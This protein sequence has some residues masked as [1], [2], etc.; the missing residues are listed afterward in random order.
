MNQPG[1]IVVYERSGDGW[2]TIDDFPFQSAYDSVGLRS[3]LRVMAD[4]LDTCLILVSKKVEGIAYQELNRLGFSI[5][6]AEQINDSVL[7]GVI[8][9]ILE[10]EKKEN[11]ATPK[12]P[13]SPMQDDHFLLDLVKLQE[14]YPDIS[15]KKAFRSFLENETF[16]SL[17]LLCAHLPPWVNEVAGQRG[18]SVREEHLP[19]GTV[20]V[21]ITPI[22]QLAEVYTENE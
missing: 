2:S 22:G 17:T 16:L 7:D 15:S 10:S 13:Y 9:D 5:F 12:A 18:L 20:R 4:R 11:P 3:A 1:K 14:V 19:A 21:T 8:R 6:E